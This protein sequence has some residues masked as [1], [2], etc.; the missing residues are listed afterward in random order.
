MLLPALP[1]PLS[2]IS[3]RRLLGATAS[4]LAAVACP[5]VLRAH[6]GPEPHPPFPAPE[7][8]IRW[9]VP[10]P[11]GGTSDLRVRQVAERLRADAGWT[12]LV[13]NRSGASGTLGTQAAL[14]APADGHTLV[15]GTIGTIALNPHLL[16]HQPYDVLR[17]LQPVTQFSRSVSLLAAHRGSGITGLAD[18]VARVQRGAALAYATPGNATISH[19]VGELLQRRAGVALTHV[20]YRGSA[21]ALQD[22]L[23]QQVPL[24]IDTPSAMWD[25]LQAGTAVPLA[26]TAAQ[27]ERLL[28]AVPTFAELGHTDLVLATWQ[29]AFTRR[30][31]AAT[32]LA[33]LHER[34]TAA[35]RHPA[36][37]ASHE[38]Q[39]NTVVAST[40]AEFESFVR[41][42]TARWGRVIAETGVRAG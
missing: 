27:R 4:A 21:P 22:F 6:S 29:G 38:E 34:I 19:L 8:P 20:P 9:I 15:L 3:R 31:V 32:T 7:R 42:E 12:V 13:D 18:L 16:P 1:A 23:A 39:I 14:E 28:P 5:T 33:T 24:L 17:D 40:P 26:L 37:V 30:G 25:H 10:F 11:P 2:P 36:I 41:N 35:L